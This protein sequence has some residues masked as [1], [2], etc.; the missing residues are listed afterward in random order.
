[1]TT[2]TSTRAQRRDRLASAA[3]MTL[4]GAAVWVALWG[5]LRPGTVAAGVLVGAAGGVVLSGIGP[6]GTAAR[7]VVRLLALL[8]LLVV[9]AWML[10][11]STISV[12]RTV[13]V[14]RVRVAPA[15]VAVRL[16]PSTEAVATIVAN[17]VTL[18][19]GTLTLDA[20]HDPD[21]TVRLIIHALDAPDTADVRRDVLTLHRLASEA[22]PRPRQAARPGAAS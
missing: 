3:V 12:T 10:L 14:R 19:P 17:A 20:S 9:F 1:M 5:D 15:V 7:P 8:R 2:A 22:F 4:T 18:T 16:P 21:G 11:V 6:R 13:C